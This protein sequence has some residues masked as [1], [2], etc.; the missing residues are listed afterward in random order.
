MDS[1]DPTRVGFRGFERAEDL[2]SLQEKDREYD[3]GNRRKGGERQPPEQG[4]EGEGNIAGQGGRIGA[5]RPAEFG[6]RTG[7]PHDGS[8]QAWERRDDHTQTTKDRSPAEQPLGA[9]DAGSVGLGSPRRGVRAIHNWQRCEPIRD[10]MEGRNQTGALPPS[11][12]TRL[13]SHRTGSLPIRTA[14]RVDWLGSS[15]RQQSDAW[16]R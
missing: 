2:P 15:L 14:D 8:R 3:E 9:S 10:A 7:H 1:L 13:G 16:D 4:Q 5:A 12:A 11:N 6:E